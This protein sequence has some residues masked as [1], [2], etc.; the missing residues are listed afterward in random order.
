MPHRRRSRIRRAI[1]RRVPKWL[2]RHDFEVFAA[3]LGILGGL[4]LVLGQVRPKSVEDVLPRAIVFGWG[5]ILVLGCIAVLTGIIA[6]SR[7]VFPQRA[8]WMRVEAMGLTALA[9]FSYMY[10]LCIL[11]VSPSTGWVAAMLI[12]T[13]GLVCHVRQATIQLEIED[14]RL[15]LGLREKT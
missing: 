8:F 2:K 13:F 7:T 15:S 3:C 14:Y 5:L 1:Y 9:Y 12:L 4:P 11:A 10:L 6:A